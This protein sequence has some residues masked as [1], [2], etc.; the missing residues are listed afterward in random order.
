MQFI[1]TLDSWL[2]HIPKICILKYNVE[3][4][5]TK[6]HFISFFIYITKNSHNNMNM[7][8]TTKVYTSPIYWKF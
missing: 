6:L 8:I 4:P 5:K 3:N 2:F 7:K 1:K